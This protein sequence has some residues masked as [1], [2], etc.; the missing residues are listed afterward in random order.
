MNK[1]ISRKLATDAIDGIMTQLYHIALSGSAENA[2]DQINFVTILQELVQLRHNDDYKTALEQMSMEGFTEYY[3]LFFDLVNAMGLESVKDLSDWRVV[4][5]KTL[6]Q[7]IS[8]TK[9]TGDIVELLQGFNAT[10]L[11]PLPYDDKIGTVKRILND[12]FVLDD[13]ERQIVKLLD[14]VSSP[15]ERTV[16]SNAL[17]EGNNSLL[18][19]LLSKIDGE[20]KLTAFRFFDEL[21]SSAKGPKETVTIPDGRTVGGSFKK[22]KIKLTSYYASSNIGGIKDK[23]YL[24][25]PFA[26]V[27]Y[28]YKKE[29]FPLPA[30]FFTDQNVLNDFIFE[31][32]YAETLDWATLTE[33]QKDDYYFEF[34]MHYLPKGFLEQLGSPLQIIIG[35]I[36]GI[37]AAGLLAPLKVALIA[38]DIGSMAYEAYQGVMLIIEA[39][40][41]RKKAGSMRELK[42][43]AHIMASGVAKLTMQVVN[44]ILSFTS[45]RKGGTTADE[46]SPT[47]RS[48][49]QNTRSIL[50]DAGYTSEKVLANTDTTSRVD[51]LRY[52]YSDEELTQ[53]I[54]KG[55]KQK[56]GLETILDGLDEKSFQISKCSPDDLYLYLKEISP[57]AAE[58]YRITGD[59]PPEIQI[60]RDP[61]F[62]TSEGAIDWQTYAPEGGYVLDGRGMAVKESYLPKQ[63][64]ILDRYGPPEG[65]Y[66]SPVVDK[67]YSYGQRALPFVKDRSMYHQYEIIGDFSKI[68]VYIDNCPDDNLKIKVQA[69]VNRY[70]NNDYSR[71]IVYRGDIAKGF[72]Q[73]GGTQ[74]ELPFPVEW[75]EQLRVLR[76]IK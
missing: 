56:K 66:T 51:T 63:G 19:T 62:L 53:L 1:I 70:Y 55:R 33:K 65:R 24:V 76:K 13:K 3:T 36:I 69:Y 20:E 12:W 57:T 49:G 45:S 22:D 68:K 21:L 16:L 32:R 37:F 46:P 44:A 4:N 59:F 35:A 38:L 71:L 7:A 18:K 10:E 58:K 61:K 11:S 67:P 73:G 41:K 34:V 64:E 48:G 52:T 15:E 2:A 28:T 29:R 60:P 26:T 17:L 27:M 54:A 25:S 39:E 5:T 40:E 9:K 31:N 75:L 42:E 50:T 23:E 72:S 30:F 47:T 8:Q 14:S 74:Y 43:S 6:P